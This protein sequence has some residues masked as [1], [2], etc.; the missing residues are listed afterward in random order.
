MFVRKRHLWKD[1]PKKMCQQGSLLQLARSNSST[2]ASRSALPPFFHLSCTSVGTA[3]RP[4]GLTSQRRRSLM[5]LAPSVAGA[6][7]ESV[8]VKPA[9]GRGGFDG[10]MGFLGLGAATLGGGVWKESTDEADAVLDLEER[11]SAI[12][13]CIFLLA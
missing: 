8:G 11:S 10:S 5:S 6:G 2:I 3:Q 9:G 12:S 1:D 7:W 4:E 13:C